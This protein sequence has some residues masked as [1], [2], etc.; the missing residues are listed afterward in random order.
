MNHPINWGFISDAVKIY[1]ALG[2]KYVEVP[3]IVNSKTVAVTLPK[4]KKEF[5]TYGGSLVGSAE[6]SFLQMMLDD[7]L[8]PGKYVAASPCFRDEQDETHQRTFFKVELIEVFNKFSYEN[9]ELRTT[10]M[11]ENAL[12]FF[13]TV[14]GTQNIKSVQTEEGVDIELNGL[15]L[16]SY[17]YRQYSYGKWTHRWV[18][19]TGIAEPRLSMALSRN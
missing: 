14:N 4:D 6:Q 15:E 2:Y 18:Y 9:S 8:A 17:G 19:G 12:S 3:W 11:V 16:G 7:N 1:R 13:K 10:V 5:A